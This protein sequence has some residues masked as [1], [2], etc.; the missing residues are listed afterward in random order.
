MLS[1]VTIGV[2]LKDLRREKFYNID[3]CSQT[4]KRTYLRTHA[5]AHAHTHTQRDN[6]HNDAQYIVIMLSVANKPIMLSVILLN[7][8][9]LS[10]VAPYT[11]INI[12]QRLEKKVIQQ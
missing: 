5:R 11:H 8:V 12:C 10:V 1:Y 3:H 6:Q 9:M 7:V 2:I 4:H